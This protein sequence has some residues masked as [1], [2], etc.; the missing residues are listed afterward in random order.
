LYSSPK[1]AARVLIALGILPLLWL[2]WHYV[3][4]AAAPFAAA[5]VLALAM[6]PAVRFLCRRGIAREAAS[7]MGTLALLA[8]LI[9]LAYFAL[10]GGA[11]LVSRAAEL[12][13]GAL[14]LL[15]ETAEALRTALTGRFGELPVELSAW[16]DASYASLTSYLAELPAELSARLLSYLTG[17]ASRAPG[18]LLFAIS[19]GIGVYFISASLPDIQTFLDTRLPERWQAR[20]LRLRRE[21][22]N[23]L[24]RY[25]R[26]Q[27][28]LAALVF[29]LL[30]LGLWLLRVKGAWL[31]ALVTALVDALPVFGSGAIL[32]PWAVAAILTGD[33]PLGLGL[34]ILWG[35]AT[36]LR[37]CVQPKLLGDQLGL[38]P[39][40]ALAALYVG[41]YLGGVWGMVLLPILALLAQRF[42]AQPD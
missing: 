7:G 3:L 13:P 8:A 40:L 41:W 16:V 29:A 28:I 35:A 30:L 19:C 6:E 22:K 34:L 21:F 36:L 39:L 9:A 32:L 2:V 38:H 37:N 31:I 24:W 5:Y 12:L 26:A 33:A 23:T 15:A 11:G 4:P 17:A 14:G 27:L 25:L 42:I 18:A 10:R 1:T 20:R